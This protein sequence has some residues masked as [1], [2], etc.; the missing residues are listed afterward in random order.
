MAEFDEGALQADF[1]LRARLQA[2]LPRLTKSMEK[3]AALLLEDPRL[4]ISHSIGELAEI[5]GVSAPTITRFCR[6]IGYGG[7]VQLRVGAAADLGRTVGQ[8][9]MAGHPGTMV[10]PDMSDQELLRTYLGTHI[11]ALQAS[12]DLVDIAALRSAAVLIAQS[13][14]VD[15]Y[16]VGGSASVVTGLVERLYQ[17]GVNVRGWSDV[18]MAIMSASCLQGTS[19][20]IGVSSS[21]STAETV[22]M[23]EVAR[24]AGATTIAITSDPLSSLASGADVVIRTAS[25]HDYRD[26][27]QLTS[28]HTQSFA[29]DLLYLLVSWQNPERSRAY[30]E[31]AEAAVARHRR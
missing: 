16:G 4:P 10:H 13:R 28:A 5:S 25:P 31:R 23:L 29:A 11:Q 12:A 3:L 24:G 7:Y 26:L 6:L 18:H 19:V 14:H 15:V 20:A 17:I 21:G 8:D 22:E 27:G 30:A 9:G 1:G 2:T